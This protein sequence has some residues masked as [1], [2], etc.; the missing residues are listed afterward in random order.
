MQF[1][2]FYRGIKNQHKGKKMKK[3]L[4]SSV[5]V[6]LCAAGAHAFDYKVSGS[7][8]SFTKWGFNNKALN[9]DTG[10]APTD[11][12]TTIF[13]QLNLNAEFAPGLKAGLGGAIGGLAWDSTAGKDSDTWSAVQN[14][15]FGVSWDRG[16][17]QNYMIQN[18]FL[19]YSYNDNFYIKAGRYES[20]KVGEWFSGYNQGAE[21]YVQAGGVKLWGFLSNRRAFAYNQWFN[22]FYRVNGTHSDLSTRNTYAVGL[23]F[24]GGGFTLSAFSYYVPGKVTAP[25]ASL[26]FVTNPSF[27]RQ[28]FNSTTKV[29]FLAPI[30]ASGFVDS[31][32]GRNWGKVEKNSY[33]LYIDQ[34]FDISEFF[35]GVGYYQN[36]GNA[37]ELIG[38][39]G[40]PI[41]IDIWTAG[42]YDIGNSLNDIIGRN[43]ITGF[44]YFGA[45]Y[46]SFDWK[47]I[48]RGTNSPRSAEQSVA[49]LLNYQIRDDFS[50]GGKLE[51][52]SD[53][54]KAG[55]TP[56]VFGDSK[57]TALTKNRTDDRSHAFFYIR[58]TF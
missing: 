58:H 22:D 39:Y 12:F 42:A 6:G 3:F 26:T 28:G 57:G 53:T 17:I 23:D 9:K 7:A 44:G 50:I 55:Y 21:G 15:Y 2:F 8:E 43:A 45:N 33:T 16:K 54:T 34:R 13:G 32:S 19:E 24:S 41:G 47:F 56:I 4:Y 29:R 18:A 36:F 14:S 49:L 35:F 20:G 37:N 30:A 52:F 1:Y 38:R 11:S 46:G 25:G 31:E 51:W 27:Q 40:N 10:A 5:V 48:G